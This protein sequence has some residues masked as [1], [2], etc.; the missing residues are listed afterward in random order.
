MFIGPFLSYN[1][2]SNAMPRSHSPPAAPEDYETRQRRAVEQ[3]MV[4]DLL[5]LLDHQE[6]DYHLNYLGILRR[7]H[8]VIGAEIQKQEGRYY[9]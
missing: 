6:Q 8:A 9:A 1:T 3:G 7:L 4:T 2:V 5:A